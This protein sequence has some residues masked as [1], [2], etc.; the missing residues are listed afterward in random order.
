MNQPFEVSADKARIAE[1]VIFDAKRFAS[2]GIGSPERFEE[3][4]QGIAGLFERRLSRLE[5]TLEL[6]PICDH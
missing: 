5:H 3:S 2:I 6:D 1:A 4:S